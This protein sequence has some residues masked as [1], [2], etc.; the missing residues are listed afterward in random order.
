MIKNTAKGIIYQNSKI[1]LLEKQHDD[2][3]YYTLPGGTQEI[4]ESLEQAVIREV[5][6]EVGAKVRVIRL[7]NI[8]EHQ[9]PSRKS[10]QTIRHK[11]EF[12]FLCELI[13]SYTPMMG[14][15]PDPH[16]IAVKWIDI[17]Q[18]ENLNLSPPV[19]VKTLVANKESSF[20][21]LGTVDALTGK[22]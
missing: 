8:Y 10:E 1:L 3:F 9:R 20:A 21:Y 17:N 14:V 12:A 16:Q 18:L 2:F 6:E 11:I 4:G 15:N 7:L 13:E 19:L 5:Y 22:P